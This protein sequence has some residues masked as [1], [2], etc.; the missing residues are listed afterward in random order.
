MI[1]GTIIGSVVVVAQDSMAVTTD[2]QMIFYYLLFAVSIVLTGLGLFS[3]S[4]ITSIVMCMIGCLICVYIGITTIYPNNSF[5]IVAIIWA[6]VS[7]FII[8]YNLYG[9]INSKRMWVSN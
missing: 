2:M 7:G 6:V 9:Y 5:S 1:M 8:I 3:R 4:Q